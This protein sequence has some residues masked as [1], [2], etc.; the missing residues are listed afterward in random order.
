MEGFRIEKRKVR[1]AY[2][3]GAGCSSGRQQ[4]G[5]RARLRAG[6]LYTQSLWLPVFA[7]GWPLRGE[8]G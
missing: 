7:L 2:R 3:L 4:D 8:A 5:G 1:E 6:G